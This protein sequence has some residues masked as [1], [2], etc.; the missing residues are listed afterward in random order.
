[1]TGLFKGF[2]DFIL[3]GNV[4]DLAVAVVIGKAFGDLVASMVANVLTPLIGLAGGVPDFS[5]WK[6]KESIEIGKF[7]N[8]AISFMIIA[9]VVYFAVVLPMNK[10]LA[11][12]RKPEVAQEVPPT[13]D[14]ALL[15]E[16]RDLLKS[17]PV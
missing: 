8:A 14:Q 15:S 11:Y 1:M 12:F 7:I 4:V 10:L 9:A 16:I 13:K 2:K 17:R 3:R 5:G 6:I